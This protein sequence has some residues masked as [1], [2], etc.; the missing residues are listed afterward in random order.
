[1]KEEERL[2]KHLRSKFDEMKR[3]RLNFL[4]DWNSLRKKNEEFVRKVHQ[5]QRA[6]EE[7]KQQE[8]L[9]EINNL[10]HNQIENAVVENQKKQKELEISPRKDKKMD[11]SEIMDDNSVIKAAHVEEILKP[12]RDEVFKSFNA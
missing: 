4:D 11:D 6:L 7:K 1:M 5:D 9:Q 10:A 12:F 8:R 2:A 3:E